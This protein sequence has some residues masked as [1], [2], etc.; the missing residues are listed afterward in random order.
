MERKS[1]LVRMTISTSMALVSFVAFG[2]AALR[3][4]N[5]FWASTAFSLAVIT[6]S[7]ALVGALARKGKARIAWA[8]FAA[9]G[10]ACLAVWLS[11]PESVGGLNGPPRMI[12]FRLFDL[13][14]PHINPAASGGQP[15]I[16]YVQVSN[17]LEVVLLA[18]IGS[19]LSR[20]AV[21]RGEE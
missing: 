8:G 9:T 4:A 10:M 6:V 1:G 19:F 15:Y 12:A 14:Q 21:V 2:L 11:T 18:T 17:S 5:E 13:L 7:V 3:N 16:H 20:F